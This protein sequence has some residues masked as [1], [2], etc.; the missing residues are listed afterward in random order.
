MNQQRR[1]AR[2]QAGLAIN[3]AREAERK[4]AH[5]GTALAASMKRR[6]AE[7]SFTTDQL[8]R[9]IDNQLGAMK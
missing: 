9:E 3:E 4:G 6:V 5:F 1:A 7:H 2:Q 8:R